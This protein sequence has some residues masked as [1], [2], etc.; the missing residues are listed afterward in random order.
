MIII[1]KVEN[2]AY[3][4]GVANNKYNNYFS[5]PELNNGKDIMIITIKMLQ[6]YK[7]KLN[8]KTINLKDNS[9]IQ[10]DDMRQVSLADLSFLQYN[11]TFYGRFGFIPIEK[12]KYKMY[13]KNQSILEETLVKSIDLVRIINEYTHKIDTIFKT[14]IIHNYNKY[15]DY[16][17][18]QWF[19]KFSRKYMKND[20]KFF[21]YL[22]SI[23][24]IELKLTTMQGVSFIYRL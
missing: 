24:F 23:I 11:D 5:T 17:L 7:D 12:N 14:K 13:V 21:N 3:I 19:H 6:K 22:I 16:N 18:I 2:I 4:E 8:I 10:C 20:C 9:F 1:D 15:R